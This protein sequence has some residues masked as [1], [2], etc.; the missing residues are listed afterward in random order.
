MAGAEEKREGSREVAVEHGR[1]LIRYRALVEVSAAA[2]TPLMAPRTGMRAAAL[3]TVLT[4]GCATVR[5]PLPPPPAAPPVGR[6]GVTEPDVTLWVEGASRVDPA[7]AAKA[8]V[9]SRAA[10][11][12]ALRGRGAAPAEGPAAAVLQVREHAVVRTGGRKANQALAVTAMIIGVV[13]AVAVIVL[14]VVSGSKSP[15]KAPSGGH[16]AAPAPARSSGGARTAPAPPRPSG[17]GAPPPGPM[18]PAPLPPPAPPG[19]NV[20]VG[21]DLPIPLPEGGPPPEAAPPW[22]EPPPPPFDPKA[23]G[24]FD[25][26]ETL[27]DLEL[28]D[29]RTGEV[30]WSASVRGWIDPRDS[31]EVS[32]LLDEVLRAQPWAR[33]PSAASLPVPPSP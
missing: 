31:E 1:S 8:L 30:L 4:F 6:V 14:A 23:R 29:E 28:E 26:D 3:A 13:V 25:G 16:A 9:E 22:V 12:A 19:V 10:L 2:Q 5:E 33:P 17:G 24:F 11:T 15:A 7:E 32:R 27:L 21:I 20:A 18:G